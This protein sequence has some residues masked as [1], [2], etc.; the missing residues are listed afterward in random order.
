MDDGVVLFPSIALSQALPAP[1]VKKSPVGNPY[2]YFGALDRDTR[3]FVQKIADETV[4][5]FYGR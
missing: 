1:L 5:R 4:R 3:A 2:D